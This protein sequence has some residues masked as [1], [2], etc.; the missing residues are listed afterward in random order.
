[1]R[2]L[3]CRGRLGG[4]VIV[5]PVRGDETR[6]NYRYIKDADHAFQSGCKAHV[7]VHRHYATVAYTAERNHA[8]VQ[9]CTALLS[10][11]GEANTCATN[12]HISISE[13]WVFRKAIMTRNLLTLRLY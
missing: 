1:V 12:A 11:S 8:E 5:E 2:L 4:F 9:Q 13:R 7:G 3:A 6:N 10:A